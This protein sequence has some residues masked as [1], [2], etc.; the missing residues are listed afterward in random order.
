MKTESD[1]GGPPQ[2]VCLKSGFLFL[3]VK[4]NGT[5]H[6]DFLTHDQVLK[7]GDI[8]VDSSWFWI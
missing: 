8:Q 4:Q 1:V 6:F 3:V 7:L 2:N 5:L